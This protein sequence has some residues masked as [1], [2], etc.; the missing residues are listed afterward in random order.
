MTDPL[1]P[2]RDGKVHVLKERCSTCVFRPGNLMNLKEGRFKDLVET[3]RR[4][5]TAFSC[6]QTLYGQTEAEAICRGYFDAY[7]EEVTPLRMAVALDVIE[8]VD[9]EKED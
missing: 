8:E 1:P 4:L 6:H 3:N 2:Y 9:H 5:D 7:K